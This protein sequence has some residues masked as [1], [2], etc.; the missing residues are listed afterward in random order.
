MKKMTIEQ[1][2]NAL[3]EF[4]SLEPSSY[5]SQNATCEYYLHVTED[6]LAVGSLSEA[7]ETFRATVKLTDEENESEDV[8][9]LVYDREKLTD[10][11]FY[12]ICNDLMEQANAWLAE[13]DD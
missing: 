7:D 11:R 9:D 6:G 8:F 1:V 3:Q 12:D 10:N 13:L 4:P 5:D 2:S